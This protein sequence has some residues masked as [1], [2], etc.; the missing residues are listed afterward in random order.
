MS[1]THITLYGDSSALFEAVKET[2]KAERG[3]EPSNAAVVRAL[4]AESDRP[5]PE[6]DPM[7]G[8]A[9]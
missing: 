1:E 6:F 8:P 9:R 3:V 2:I 4:M 5:A 7:G